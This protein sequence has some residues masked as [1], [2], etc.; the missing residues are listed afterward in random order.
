MWGDGREGEEGERRLVAAAHVDATCGCARNTVR[1]ADIGPAVGR[2]AAK[3][4]RELVGGKAGLQSPHARKP[5][6]ENEHTRDALA[7]AERRL[8][9][10]DDP[11]TRNFWVSARGVWDGGESG[12]GRAHVV[13]CKLDFPSLEEAEGGKEFGELDQAQSAQHPKQPQIDD[14]AAIGGRKHRDVVDRGD[15]D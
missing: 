12:R 3:P 8:R 7:Q 5:V 11:I 10:R 1:C 6:C 2:I 13:D 4:S 15:G 14:G 9:G